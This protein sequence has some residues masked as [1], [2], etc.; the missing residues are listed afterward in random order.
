MGKLIGTGTLINAIAIIGGGF[1]GLGIGSKLKEKTSQTVMHAVAL[2]VVFLGIQTAFEGNNL[3]AIL[4]GLVIGGI[5]GETLN[6]EAHLENLGKTVEKKLKA[7]K[8]NFAVGFVTATILFVVGPMAILGGIQDGIGNGYSIL[9]TKSALDGLSSIA[10]GASLGIGVPFSAIPV[11]IYQGLITLMAN[12]FGDIA[13]ANVL[14]SLSGSGGILILAIGL[15]MLGLTKIRVT[16]LL[17]GI[18][19]APIFTLLL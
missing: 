6:L 2:V 14:A 4:L 19:L 11:A 15:N 5:I 1:F 8:G 18:I 3:V 13:S 12:F 9:L 7:E 17:P 10:L 16:N